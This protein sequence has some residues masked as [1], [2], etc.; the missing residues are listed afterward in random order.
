[1]AITAALISAIIPAYTL[2][3]FDIPILAYNEVDSSTYKVGAALVD[4][5]GEITESTSALS[6]S[7]VITGIALQAG[8]NIATAPEY[9]GYGLVYPAG[10][11]AGQASSTAGAALAVAPLLMVPALQGVVFEGTLAG[12]TGPEDEAILTTHVFT[13]FGLT[14]DAGSGFWFVDI[15]L[16]GANAAVYVIGIKNPQDLT[17][18]TTKGARVFFVFRPSFTRM[19]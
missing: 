7:N 12:G 10:S 13:Q 19:A 17:F 4:S 8:Q 11:S 1:M 15:D 5:S 2:G 6:T 16:T 9:P 18:G 3:G 14:K